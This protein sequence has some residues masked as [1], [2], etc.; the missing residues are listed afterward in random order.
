[1]KITLSLTAV[2]LFATGAF[3][4]S[5]AS[6]R[7]EAGVR[8][9]GTLLA[10]DLDLS[11]K[12]VDEGKV[13]LIIYYT[14]DGARAE[15]LAQ[16]LRVTP[17]GEP[18]KIGGLPV[19]VET[20]SDAAFKSYAKRAPAGVFVSQPPDAKTLQSI[21]QFG[22]THR[23]IIYSPFEG[24]VERG[25]LGG[26]S[27]EAQVRPYVNQATMQASQISLK[28]FFMKVTKVYQ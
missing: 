5:E 27:I 13:L 18:K 24:H 10:A 1:M 2:L 28:P 20:T 12:T 3:A 16:M 11:K 21:I 4:E 15:Q 26:L 14:N 7:T 6:R 23:T 25:V 19:Q 8:M 22:I 17:S 9:F